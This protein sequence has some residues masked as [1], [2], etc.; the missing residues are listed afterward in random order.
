[1]IAISMPILASSGC[2]QPTMAGTA[3]GGVEAAGGQIGQEWVP[4]KLAA[5]AMELDE[6]SMRRRC[7]AELQGRGLAMFTTPPEGGR[8]QWFVNVAA[9]P[10][11]LPGRLGELYQSPDLTRYPLAKVAEALQRAAVAEAF[12]QAL[13]TR[14]GLVRDW[15]DAFVEE[16]RR[17]HPELRIGR[18]G[19][20][21]W[22]KAYKHPA[23]LVRLIDGRGGDRRSQGDPAAWAAFKGLFLHQNQPSVKQCWE[24]TRRLSREQ[25]LK[26]CTLAS[27]YNQLDT[28]IPPEQQLYHRQPE[29]WR[30]QMAPYI[31]QDPEA[32]AAGERWISDHKQTDLWCRWNSMILRP[33]LT[34]WMD[35]RTRKICGWVLS[36]SPNSTTILAALRH[37]LMDAANFGGPREVITDCGRDYEAWV[38]HGRTKKERRKRIRPEI[39]RGRAYGILNA[40]KIEAR[41]AIP[42]SPNS[43]SRQERFYRS[44]SGFFKTF[45]TY[46]GEDVDT[47]PERLNAVLANPRLIPSFEHVQARLAKHI[48]GYNA[49]ADHA[50]ADL[51]D[52][53]EPLSPGEALRRWCGTRRVLADPGALDLLLQQWHK[54]VTMGRNGITLVLAGRAVAYGGFEAALTP[55]KARFK[56]DRKPLLVSYDPHD[57]RT[58]RVYDAQWRF[59]C[60]ARMND[61][62][63]RHG[64]AIALEYVGEL[65]RQKAHYEKSLKH[66]GQYSITRALT[67][68]EYL[69][70]IAADAAEQKEKAAVEPAAMQIIRTPID[71]QAKEVDRDRLRQAVGS[72]S[73]P[74]PT[75]TGFSAAGKFRNQIRPK[76]R[77]QQPKMNP[78]EKLREQNHEW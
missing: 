9:D 29:T 39:D 7:R 11:L 53:G 42:Y 12:G 22:H 60:T 55:F 28:R 19:V 26:W 31:P 75:K 68:Q 70:T 4:A 27:C 3:A 66:M 61:L 47:R 49:S 6:G 57:I 10:R 17:K 1:M 33:W 72:E 71:S 78:W 38:F 64:D 35:W 5:Q 15:L 37:G 18:R 25:G 8:S 2:S 52:G 34:T 36:N 65:N 56:K 16:Q 54:P 30:K 67:T 23:D 44:L 50:I 41:F 14:R 48:E 63:G 40:L 59:V 58:I 74:F 69:G 24:E 77:E 21:S 20:Y 13:G 73:V 32:W 46:A 76:S 51:V 62:G 43:K 45:E